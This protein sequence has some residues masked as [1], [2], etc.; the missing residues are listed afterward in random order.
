MSVLEIIWCLACCI[1]MGE[2][3]TRT[4]G[5]RAIGYA[6]LGVFLVGGAVLIPILL[7]IF[8]Q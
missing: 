8:R 1:I 2:V 6:A 5:S 3:W 7:F 4:S